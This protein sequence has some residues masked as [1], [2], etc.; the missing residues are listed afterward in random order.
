M[1]SLQSAEI[2]PVNMRGDVQLLELLAPINPPRQPVVAYSEFHFFDSAV[3][4][5]NV[6]CVCVRTPITRRLNK[7]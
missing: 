5:G 2:R 4:L 6:R 3:H 7:N 1:K